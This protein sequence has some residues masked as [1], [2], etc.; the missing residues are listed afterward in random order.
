MSSGLVTPDG[1]PAQRHVGI[2]VVQTSHGE[3]PVR[4]LD[5]EALYK[6]QIKPLDAVATLAFQDGDR[7]M[8]TLLAI[9]ELAKDIYARQ[10]EGPRNFQKF[11]EDV[12]LRVQDLNQTV[13]DFSEELGKI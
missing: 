3:F 8:L 5:L 4:S 12:G 11:C 1:K 10:P 6:G 2:P 13:I 7:H 9:L